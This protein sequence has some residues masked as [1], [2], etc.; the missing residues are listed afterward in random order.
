MYVMFL[1]KWMILLRLKRNLT[2]LGGGSEVAQ[3]SLVWKW[4][5][6]TPNGFPFFLYSWE[7][8]GTERGKGVSKAMKYL[9]PLQFQCCLRCGGFPQVAHEMKTGKIQRIWGREHCFTVSQKTSGFL[10]SILAYSRNHHSSNSDRWLVFVVS[11][12]HLWFT[13]SDCRTAP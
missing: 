12:N 4:V 5:L 6:G 11:N 10:P 9:L 7:M 8:I 3:T 13:D 1:L 2:A